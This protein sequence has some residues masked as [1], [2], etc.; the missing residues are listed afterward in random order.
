MFVT[1]RWTIDNKD[2]GSRSAQS[3]IEMISTDNIDNNLRLAMISPDNINIK[4]MLVIEAPIPKFP[5]IPIPGYSPIPILPIP[6]IADTFADTDTDTFKNNVL[7]SLLLV[8]FFIC[9]N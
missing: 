5:P 7:R 9:G 1:D 8:L 4:L 2:G 3:L 6:Q